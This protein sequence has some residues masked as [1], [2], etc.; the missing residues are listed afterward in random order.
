MSDPGSAGAEER[1][2]RIA[3]GQYGFGDVVA[4]DLIRHGENQVYRAGF[5]DGS[6]RAVRLQRH[7]TQT[8]DAI[9]SE[10]SWMSAAHQAGIQVPNVQLTSHG[11]D[12]ALVED[13]MGQTRV[14]VVMSWIEGRQLADLDPDPVVFRV[15]QLLAALH[16]FSA[17]WTGPVWFDRHRWDSDALVGENPRWG[18]ATDCCSWDARTASM[19]ED[20]RVEV[21]GILLGLG[22]GPD[23]F[24]LIHADPTPTNLLIGAG[25]S[26]SLVD[27]D[28][29]GFGWFVYDLAVALWEYEEE[30]AF[31]EIK[32]EL[33]SGYFDI[34]DRAPVGVE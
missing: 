23:R 9:R 20:A 32:H 18:R 15:G 16:A 24:G 14:V 30:D 27:F 29:C 19:L 1:L 5:R 4:L 31:P 17:T 21:S 13:D 6:V 11:E 22:T 25:N 28:D 7:G 8:V 3:L 33:L 26:V 12:V 34:A 10:V 2:V